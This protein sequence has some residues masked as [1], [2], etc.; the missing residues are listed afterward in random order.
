MSDNFLII[1]PSNKWGTPEKS[2]L[3]DCLVLKKFKKNVKIQK[4]VLY[5]KNKVIF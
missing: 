5:A 4:I 1:C 2:A 3:R